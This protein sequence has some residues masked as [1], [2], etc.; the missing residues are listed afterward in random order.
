MI[1]KRRKL[2]LIVT[3]QV[4]LY[5]GTVSSY[6]MSFFLRTRSG[7]FYTTPGSLYTTHSSLYTTSDSFYTLLG[8]LYTTVISPYTTPDSLYTTLG[9][10]Y[11]WCPQPCGLRAPMSQN[12]ALKGR[13]FCIPMSNDLGSYII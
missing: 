6:T 5:I 7:S 4:L 11:K 1:Y 3:T 13:L 10:P 9:S 8:S 12:N 2:T